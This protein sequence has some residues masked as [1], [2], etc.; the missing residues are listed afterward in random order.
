M[1]RAGVLAVALA[2]MLAFVAPATNVANAQPTLPTTTTVT[3]TPSTAPAGTA[4]TVTA[5]VVCAGAIAG[6]AGVVNFFDTTATPPAYLA[7]GTLAGGP[8]TATASITTSFPAP[9]NTHTITAV[10]GGD[11]EC[12]PSLGTVT[13][14]ATTTTVAV[15]G[16][17]NPA[18]QLQDVTFTAVVTCTGDGDPTGSV[19]F[20][21]ATTAT[22]LGTDATGTAGPG[23]GQ[24][25]FTSPAV[26]FTQPPAPHTIEAVYTSTNPACGNATGTTVENIIPL[27][28]STTTVSASPNPATVGTATTLTAAITCAGGTPQGGNVSFFDG[29]TLLGTVPV[30]TGSPATVSFITT[31]A[32]PGPHTID[33]VYSGTTTCAASFGTV[34]VMVNPLVSGSTTTVSANPANPGSGQPVVLT[35]QVTCPAVGASPVGGTVTF[36]DTT[37][38]TTLGTATVGAGGTAS[39]TV[40]AGFTAGSHTISAA[41][42][43]TADCGPST[44]TLALNVAATQV[45]SGNIF[46]NVQVTGPATITPGS[47]IFGDVM[48]SGTGS[49]NATGVYIS[50]KL[51]AS[52]GSGLRLCS[53][54][55]GG[56]T[57][58]T[59][60]HGVVVIGDGGDDGPPPCAGNTLN[61]SVTLTANTGFLEFSANIVGG[62]AAV[63]NNTTTISV[64]PENAPATELEGNRISGSLSCLGNVP[65]PADDGRPNTVFGSKNGQ[66]AAL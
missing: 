13:V 1:R 36:T 56:S 62:S 41:F 38:A 57:S 66:C 24:R 2:G 63:N 17:P 58:I 27:P 37:T 43:G 12:L 64:P 26:I 15:T 34:T 7:T 8:G 65:P 18:T 25:T 22:V 48:I 19:T 35:A 28:A 39:V 40:P 29:A 60:V 42:G 3:A 44:G 5:T 61:G 11:A 30:T 33:A 32:T 9:P 46:H 55:V 14:T 53:S 31:F 49:L 50:G 51:T 54:T 52:G 21:D 45:I 16:T 47:R 10:Y 6:P 23:A 4:V 20:T 59:G